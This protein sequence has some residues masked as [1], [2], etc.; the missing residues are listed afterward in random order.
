[1]CSWL[2]SSSPWSSSVAPS[3][4]VLPV[5]SDPLERRVERAARYAVET[6]AERDPHAGAPTNG[7]R[8]D[9]D[10]YRC[11]AQASALGT[12]RS[13]RRQGAKHLGHYLTCRHRRVRLGHGFLP[14]HLVES[15]ISEGSVAAP[16]H[17]R[18]PSNPREREGNLRW[19]RPPSRHSHRPCAEQTQSGCWRLCVHP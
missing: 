11:C 14:A 13:R 3:R 18:P 1:M 9:R 5:A 15:A 19:H 4:W 8:D 16:P 12:D 10:V 6:A 17:P 7:H 2:R